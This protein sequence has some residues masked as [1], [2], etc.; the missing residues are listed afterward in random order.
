[1][2]FIEGDDVRRM[3]A[4]PEQLER[5]K[6]RAVGPGS[7]V[8]LAQRSAHNYRTRRVVKEGAG[9]AAKA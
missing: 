1:M 5:A 6:L 7:G 2:E 8:E 3:D 9:F 4:S